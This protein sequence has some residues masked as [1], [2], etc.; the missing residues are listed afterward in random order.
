LIE[1]AIGLALTFA[2]VSLLATAV[3]EGMASILN[4]RGKNLEKLV[5]SVLGDDKQ[6][7]DAFFNHALLKSMVLGERRPSYLSSDMF[8]TTLLNVLSDKLAVKPRSGTPADFLDAVK[9]SPL[10]KRPQTKALFD[11]LDVLVQGVEHDWPRFELAVRGWFDQAGERS[12]GWYK[13]NNNFWLFIIGSALAV[14]LNLDAVRIATALWND[15]ALRLRTVAQAEVALADYQKRQDSALPAKSALA[16]EL[17]SKGGATAPGAAPDGKTGSS[18]GKS[19]ASTGVVNKAPPGPTTD[20]AG[21][22]N[23]AGTKPAPQGSAQVTLKDGKMTPLDG[24]ST[25]DKA[26]G[27]T[28]PAATSS[29]TGEAAGAKA[30]PKVA[31]ELAEALMLAQSV[32][33]KL[34]SS[35]GPSGNVSKEVLSAAMLDLLALN[36][37]MGEMRPAASVTP[38][39]E[40]APRVSPADCKDD[41]LREICEAGLAFRRLQA[42]GI[43]MGWGGS[44]PTRHFSEPGK[45]RSYG[46]LALEFVVMLVGWLVTAVAVTL[47]APF[48]FDTLSKLVKLRGSGAKADTGAQKQAAAASPPGAAATPTAGGGTAVLMDGDSLAPD[49]RKLSTSEIEVIQ[50]RLGVPNNQVT[51]HLDATTR[52]FI[53]RWQETMGMQRTSLLTAQQINLLL[54]QG[55]V[56]PTAAAGNQDE[57]LG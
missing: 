2:L 38:A 1:V 52:T 54:T 41:D 44:I 6:L 5:L 49:E 13:R 20:A 27:S 57:F 15:P 51:G 17:A 8:T 34:D 11:T 3:M 48:W 36:E 35:V 9:S 23:A 39:K 50:Q 43:P 42:T 12:I 56:R 28:A 21:K 40:A 10:G 18:D 45:D 24:K 22:T 33:S 29:G 31:P 4:H 47:G 16:G 46:M 30:A 7:G 32:T 25:P 53:G 14:I 19:P 55:P 37:R 26:A